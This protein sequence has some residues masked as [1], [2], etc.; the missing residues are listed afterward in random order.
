MTITIASVQ[1]N[2]Q[3]KLKDNLAIIK[4]AIK[5]ASE[6]GANLVVLPE[7]ACYM[8]R[9]SDIAGDFD[10]L[11]YTLSALAKRHQ[12]HLLAGTLP[13]P[14]HPDGSP[15]DKS[16]QTS[17]L[18]DNHG[19]TLARYNKIHLF[20]AT[21][22]DGVGNYDESQTFLAGD[23]PVLATCVIAGQTVTLGLMICFDLRFPK[24]AQTLRQ[25][26]ADILL[27]PSA[28]THAT[29]QAYWELLIKARAIDS[30]CMVVGSAQ[31]GTHKTAHNE[32]QTWGHSMIVRA[33]G[34]MLSSIH[35]TECH[36]QNSDSEHTNSGLNKDFLANGS[37]DSGFLDSGFLL[38]IADFDP[39][40]QKT[41]RQHLPIFACHRLA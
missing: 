4:T 13:C 36:T 29:G 10:E 19:N 16:Y 15:S 40:A 34:Q 2:S 1:L 11:S 32:R 14:Y 12:V 8:G 27:A 38:A 18:F 31:G 17:L 25:L 21:V 26:G 23:R 7:N 33:D 3:N 5:T 37:L 24:L 28:F 30:Q 39:K 20:R 9:Q 6:R 35:S 22:G 41:I